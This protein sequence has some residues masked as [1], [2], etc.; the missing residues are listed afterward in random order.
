M[1]SETTQINNILLRGAVPPSI[2]EEVAKLLAISSSGLQLD[3]DK[4][5]LAPRGKTIL[6][7]R[8]EIIVLTRS[9]RILRNPKKYFRGRPTIGSVLL[10]V[11][12]SFKLIISIY[13]VT[14][15]KKRAKVYVVG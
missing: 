14:L 1:K 5:E 3:P 13:N 10:H 7:P 15:F 11:H 2:K 9:G 8:G 6:L 4:V 12:R